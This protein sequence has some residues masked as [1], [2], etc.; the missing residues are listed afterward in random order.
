MSTGK[1]ILKFLSS[2]QFAVIL[3]TVLAGACCAGSFI[4]QGHTYEWYAEVYSERTAAVIMALHLDDAFHSWWFVLITLF[5]CLNLFFCNIIR[6]PRLI[7]RTKKTND[8]LA[9]IKGSVTCAREKIKKP[10]A[11]FEKLHMPKA[12]TLTSEDGKTV[13][14]SQ[15]NTA[16]IWGAWIC[17]L[18]ILLLIAGFG[19]GQMLKQEYTV[20]GVPGQTKQVGDTSYWMTIDNFETRRN[21]DGTLDQYVTELTVRDMSSAD[22]TGKSASVTVNGPASLYG[23]RIY[24]NSTGWAADMTITE[25]GEFLQEEVLCAGEYAR[26]KDKQDLVIYLNAVYPDLIAG[27]DGMPATAS[28]EPNN[29][30]Y[31]YSVYYMNEIIG[32][33]V[34]QKD[35][36]ITIDDYTVTFSDPRSYTLVQVKKDSFAWLAFAGGMLTLAGLL[37]AFYLQRS[38]VW[39]VKEKEGWTVYGYSPKAGVLFEEQLDEAVRSAGKEQ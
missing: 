9:V 37:L 20:Y 27:E 31:L 1:K 5:L 6:L 11:L 29:P 16:G 25:G 4:S 2:M 33:N 21:P 13:L 17:H 38:A 26:V 35:E 12:R 28:D 19:L 3:L 30:G 32:M 22:G 34:L 39:A 23:W 10:E 24:Q 15:K 8:P 36:Q 7:A 18:G 14:F